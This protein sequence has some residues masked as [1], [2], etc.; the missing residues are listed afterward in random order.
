MLLK[1]KLKYSTKNLSAALH[2]EID[3]L[4]NKVGVHEYQKNPPSLIYPIY[5][6][7]PS[8]SYQW[9]LPSY[10]FTSSWI[11]HKSSPIAAN[12]WV[13][14]QLPSPSLKF[15]I[16]HINLELVMYSWPLGFAKDWSFLWWLVKRNLWLL[17][18]FEC[19]VGTQ[20]YDL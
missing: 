3:P 13:G 17:R 7:P 18:C 5:L 14:G 4:V 8:S 9:A 2:A 10:F 6:N 11:D 19:P 1:R 16:L 15:C 20:E 12:S